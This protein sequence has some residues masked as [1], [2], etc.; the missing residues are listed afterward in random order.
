MEKTSI[1][2]TLNQT[3][4]NLIHLLMDIVK[5]IPRTSGIHVYTPIL[6]LTVPVKYSYLKMPVVVRYFKKTNQ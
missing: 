2:K 5:V 4:V 3:P 1:A 6:S